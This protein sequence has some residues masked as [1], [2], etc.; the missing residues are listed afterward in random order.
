MSLPELMFPRIPELQTT[1]MPMPGMRRR[2]VKAQMK[3]YPV[4]GRGPKINS[5]PNF[6]VSS[7]REA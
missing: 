6:P 4:Y 5:P 3:K 2:D 1:R 7:V